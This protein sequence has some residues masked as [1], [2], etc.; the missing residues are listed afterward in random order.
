VLFRSESAATAASDPRPL[1]ARQLDARPVDARQVD[2]APWHHFPRGAVAGNFLHGQLEWLAG[3]GFALDDSL[4]LQQ[5]LL[6]RCERQGWGHRADEVLAWLGR[7]CSVSLPPLGAPLSALHSLSPELEFWFPD[8]GLRTGRLDGLCR[9]HLLP[10][11]PRPALPERT[12][13]G[14]LMG[15]ADLVFEH[16]GR[17]WVLDYKSNA[18]GPRDADYT[19]EAMDAAMLA[20]RYDVQAALYLLAL[21]RLLKSRLGEAYR[22]AQQLGGALYFFLRGV[23][24]ASAGCCHLAA[25]PA[26]IEALDVLLP[27]AV[28]GAEGGLA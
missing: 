20:H 18:L 14:L 21:H 12:L 2:T 17:Y 28:A 3:E 24:S 27:P 6:R 26:L 11:R 15:F 22:P 19:A 5:A 9:L 8:D 1:D 16:Q 25:P 13:S 7:A 4:P 10:G 23:H